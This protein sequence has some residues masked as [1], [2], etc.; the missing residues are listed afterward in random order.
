MLPGRP[1]LEHCPYGHPFVPA[2]IRWR[3]DGYKYIV[4]MCRVCIHLRK[5]MTI[6]KGWF[7]AYLPW[8]ENRV[9]S[10]QENSDSALAHS[11]R[12]WSA[13]QLRTE[14]E[15]AYAWLFL[16]ALPPPPWMWC[17]VCQIRKNAR[18]G[19]KRVGELTGAYLAATQPVA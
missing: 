18:V 4:R 7:Y 1:K 13:N 10:W 8:Q 5:H 14:G 12:D 11:D 16:R 15:W 2:N 3:L 17:S 9:V 19:A 6:P